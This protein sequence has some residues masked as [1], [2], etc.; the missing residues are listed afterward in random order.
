MEN[1]PKKEQQVQPL[2]APQDQE[3]HVITSSS[4]PGE[5]LEIRTAVKNILVRGIPSMITI[6]SIFVVHNITQIFIGQLGDPA[7]TAGV[8]LANMMMSVFCNSI[9]F[10]L[11]GAQDTL[12]S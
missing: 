10:G 9:G 2:L 8:G 3:A 1:E 6:F 7:L 12:V 4:K 11:N 5:V